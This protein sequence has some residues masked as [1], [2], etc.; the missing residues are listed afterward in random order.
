MTQEA[1]AGSKA[2]SDCS[3]CP[4]HPCPQ[5]VGSP[6]SLSTLECVCHVE[7]SSY[8]QSRA[9]AVRALEKGRLWPLMEQ[10]T[11]CFPRQS[12]PGALPGT[13]EG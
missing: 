1:W 4:R 3:P 6:G 2:R 12:W 10:L 9:G 13:Q 11:V 8:P 5:S 7:A